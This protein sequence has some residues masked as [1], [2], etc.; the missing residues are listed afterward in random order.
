M[1][2][3]ARTGGDTAL[4]MRDLIRMAADGGIH[5][6]AVFDHHSERPL[7]LARETRTATTDQRI[8]CYAPDG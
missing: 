6:L 7:Y 8:I 3:P 1:P 5:Y 4:P 2:G